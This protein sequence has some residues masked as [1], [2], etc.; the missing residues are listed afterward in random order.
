MS[1]QVLTER[2]AELEAATRDVLASRDAL[3]VERAHLAEEVTRLREAASRD[4]A[5]ITA[6]T[7]T[8]GSCR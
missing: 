6:A 2:L 4:A 7:K 8:A 5:E 1:L 3:A